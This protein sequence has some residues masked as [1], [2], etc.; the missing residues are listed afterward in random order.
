MKHQ[1][2]LF[3]IV[4]VL[5]AAVLLIFTGAPAQDRSEDRNNPTLVT[6]NEITDDLDG[7]EN[8]YFYKFTAG[9]GKLTVTLEVDANETNAG[10][11]LDLFTD[12]NKPIM[13]NML[14][15]AIDGGSDRG[16][17]S[18]KLRKKQIIIIRI[19][20]LKY[21]TSGR[22]T[23]TY[24]ILLEGAVDFKLAAPAE[25]QVQPET[26]VAAPDENAQNNQPDPAP[27]AVAAT[28][29]PEA[30]RS[31]PTSENKK[32]DVVDRAL[33]KEKTKSQKLRGLLDKVKAKI[34]D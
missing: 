23:G 34:P 31:T 10:A 7:A 17:R 22:Y 13:Q 2:R 30:A 29:N 15:Q 4:S 14:V 25:G 12:T 27:S 6:A 3:F 33:E 16:S 28:D 21:G 19:K 32:P 5:F 26:P 24:K 9:P 1:T 11:N 20:G 8:E 18:V